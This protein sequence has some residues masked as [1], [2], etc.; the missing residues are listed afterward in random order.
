MDSISVV[1]IYCLNWFFAGTKLENFANRPDISQHFPDLFAAQYPT[2]GILSVLF[3]KFVCGFF[4][5][6]KIKLVYSCSNLSSRI[7][8]KTYLLLAKDL[9]TFFSNSLMHFEVHQCAV[10]LLLEYSCT[11]WGELQVPI[12]WLGLVQTFWRRLGTKP[13]LVSTPVHWASLVHLQAWF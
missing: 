4:F 5:F 13:I 12:Q 8:L 2:P 1:F 3:H 9:V 7:K 6:V 10:L 11:L